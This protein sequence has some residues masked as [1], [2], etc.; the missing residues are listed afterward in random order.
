MFFC[1]NWSIHC[2]DLILEKYAGKGVALVT[3]APHTSNVFQILDVLLSGPL[4]S[5]KKYISRND[6]DLT[7]IDHL[8][9][10]FKT[11]YRVSHSSVASADTL[12]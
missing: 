10:I 6:T 1:D 11:Y 4:K 2:S 9:K 7:G 8:V 5:T 3:S 12:D